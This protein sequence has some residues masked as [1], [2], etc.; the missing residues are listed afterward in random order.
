MPGK[1]S[2][3]SLPHD[4][5][6][7]TCNGAGILA[8]SPLFPDAVIECDIE[9]AAEVMAEIRAR[10]LAIEPAR[11]RDDRHHS[12]AVIWLEGRN[13]A[14]PHRKWWEE[15][16]AGG[17]WATQ[18]STWS[19]SPGP[20]NRNARARSG[21]KTKSIGRD[22]FGPFLMPNSAM[23]CAAFFATTYWIEI[24]TI[25]EVPAIAP[26]PKRRRNQE[27]L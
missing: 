22:H 7:T 16:V 23:R 1:G 15:R 9:G 26:K 24:R 13:G 20:R 18:Q 27:V 12:A 19:G 2:D 4:S 25:A 5:I 10:G 21:R 17:R 14:A 11:R 8:V 3:N 6:A